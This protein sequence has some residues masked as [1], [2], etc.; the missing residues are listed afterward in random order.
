LGIKAK[1]IVFSFIGNLKPTDVHQVVLA[2]MLAKSAPTVKRT[3]SAKL[4]DLNG[5]RNV[6]VRFDA[7]ESSNEMRGHTFSFYTPSHLNWGSVRF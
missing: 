4:K 6:S 3:S 1:M 2:L 5:H 7:F